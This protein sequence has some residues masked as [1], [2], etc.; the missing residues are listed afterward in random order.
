MEKIIYNSLQL[1]E[2]FHL[3]FLRWFSQKVKANLYIIKGGANLRF[4]FNSVRY[5]EDMDIDIRGIGVAE[6]KKIVMAILVSP[7]F[8]EILKPF[9]IER[10]VAPNITLAKQTETT[11]RF[12]I[13][14][15]TRSGEDHFTKI[16][17]SR[18]KDSMEEGCLSLPGIHVNVSRPEKIKVKAQDRT[19]KVFVEEYD[20]LM[21]KVIQHEMDHLSGKLLI[22]YLNPVLRI[23]TVRKLLRNFNK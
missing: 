12:K 21:A 20:G 15:I 23:I 18:R 4:F 2:L 22:D 1:I 6:L 13:H 8:G 3:I 14:L 9:A 10:I 11:Q 5:S 16:E 7:S 19:G 17:F